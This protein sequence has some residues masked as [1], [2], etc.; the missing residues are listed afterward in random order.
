LTSAPAGSLSFE[1]DELWKAVAIGIAVDD[2]LHGAELLQVDVVGPPTSVA[3]GSE[4]GNFVVP[5]DAGACGIFQVVSPADAP[6][7]YTEENP[8]HTPTFVISRDRDIAEA[9]V[10]WRI[11][12]QISTDSDS[13]HGGS[14]SGLQTAA[15]ISD[16][17]D[18]ARGDNATTVGGE[19]F[20]PVGVTQ[21]T[22]ELNLTDDIVYEPTEHFEFVIDVDQGRCAVAA[23]I[24]PPKVCKVCAGKPEAQSSITYRYTSQ[25]ANTNL[26]GSQA[27]G[28]LTGLFPNKTNLTYTSQPSNAQQT[29]AVVDGSVFTVE[30]AFSY[31]S[32]FTLGSGESFTISTSCSVPLWTGDRFGPLTVLSGGSCDLGDTRYPPVGRVPFTVNVSDVPTTTT[33]TSQSTTTSLVTS[34]TLPGGSMEW[35]PGEYKDIQVAQTTYD[36]PWTVGWRIDLCTDATLTTCG[37]SSS[38]V[39][40][41]PPDGMLVYDPASSSDYSGIISLGLNESGSKSFF[42]QHLR[43]TIFPI[44]QSVGSPHVVVSNASLYLLLPAH[45]QP[46]GYFQFTAATVNVDEGSEHEITISR[47]RGLAGRVRVDLSSID[48]NDGRI[49]LA[50]TS[51]VFE[52]SD[53]A[54]SVNISVPRSDVY[55]LGNSYTLSLHQATLVSTDAS[56]DSVNSVANASLVDITG[57]SDTIRI[58]L[59]DDKDSRGRFNIATDGP[60][61]VANGYSKT[62]QINRTGG[63]LGEVILSLVSTH[64][65]VAFS[66]PR[67]E[68]LLDSKDVC[69][70]RLLDASLNSAEF[71]GVAG[72]AAFSNGKKFEFFE[73]DTRSEYDLQKGEP[74]CTQSP[75]TIPTTAYAIDTDAAATANS[76]TMTSWF[77]WNRIN[78]VVAAGRNMPPAVL[79]LAGDTLQLH[80]A[81]PTRLGA[82]TFVDVATFSVPLFENVQNQVFMVLVTSNSVVVY[83][84]STKRASLLNFVLMQEVTLPAAT[85]ASAVS[86]SHL[87]LYGRHYLAFAAERDPALVWFNDATGDFVVV[88]GGLRGLAAAESFTP[89]WLPSQAACYGSSTN[90]AL[91]EAP[92]QFALGVSASNG[93]MVYHW[94]HNAQN[95]RDSFFE[96]AQVIGGQSRAF[97]VF[98][99]PDENVT[100]L[101]VEPP[102]GGQEGAFHSVRL[103]HLDRGA[104][105]TDVAAYREID[106][107]ALSSTAAG[108]SSVVQRSP[109]GPVEAFVPTA[110]GLR[111]QR[112]GLAVDPET[113]LSVVPAELMFSQDERSK[114]VTVTSAFDFGDVDEKVFEFK[115]ANPRCSNVTDCGAAV[116]MGEKTTQQVVV[117]AAAPALELGR[118]GFSDKDLGSDRVLLCEEG[119]C[120][121]GAAVKVVIPVLRWGKS[122]VKLEGAN[123]LR[124]RFTGPGAFGAASVFSLA[125]IA[126]AEGE[127]GVEAS[128]GDCEEVVGLI[129]L[130][131]LPDAMPEY[132]MEVGIELLA[133]HTAGVEVIAARGT[134]WLLVEQSD[135]PIGGVKLVDADS[136]ATTPRVVTESSSFQFNVTS[137]ALAENRS[138]S[139]H[140][141][142]IYATNGNGNGDDASLAEYKFDPANGT[143]SIA[144]GD[145]VSTVVTVRSRAEYE[146]KQTFLLQLHP[147]SDG[148]PVVSGQDTLQIAVAADR[149]A[150]GVLVP[151]VQ[152]GGNVVVCEAS[153]CPG[154]ARRRSLTGITI[155][156]TMGTSGNTELHFDLLKK[157][158]AGSFEPVG[159]EHVIA[160][161]DSQPS[162]ALDCGDNA[163]A[164]TYCVYILNS[165]E[166]TVTSELR[167]NFTGYFMADDGT[168]IP[169]ALPS[170]SYVDIAVPERAASSDGIR[171]TRAADQSFDTDANAYILPEAGVATTYGVTLDRL[172][173]FFGDESA[174]WELVS[175]LSGGTGDFAGVQGPIQFV[176]GA[177]SSTFQLTVLSDTTPELDDTF[178][179]L[180]TKGDG[181]D[182]A[183]DSAKVVIPAN[184]NPFGVFT[185]A[186]ATY[187]YKDPEH[188]VHLFVERSDG[189]FG[190]VDVHFQVAGALAG[191]QRA[192][193]PLPVLTIGAGESSSNTTLS[194]NGPATVGEAIEVRIIDATLAEGSKGL[195][196]IADAEPAFVDSVVAASPKVALDSA[197]YGRVVCDDSTVVVTEPNSG[198]VDVVFKL[199]REGVNN[200]AS[201]YAYTFAGATATEGVDFAVAPGFEQRTIKFGKNQ[202]NVDFRLQVKADDDPETEELIT[203]A[204]TSITGGVVDPSAQELHVTIEP[205][206]FVGGL[207]GFELLSTEITSVRFAPE[208]RAGI[209]VFGVNILRDFGTAGAAKVTLHGM[210]GDDTTVSEIDFSVVGQQSTTYATGPTLFTTEIDFVDGETV[211]AVRIAVTGDSTPEIEKR[212][213]LAVSVEGILVGERCSVR[214]VTDRTCS[215]SVVNARS[216]QLDMVTPP[217]DNPVGSF[218]VTPGSSKIQPTPLGRSAVA[219]IS[220]AG[221][222]MFDVDLAV[223]LSR[224]ANGCAGAEKSCSEL[225]STVAS[226]DAAMTSVELSSKGWESGCFVQLSLLRE[227]LSQSTVEFAVP[228][229]ARVAIDTQVEIAIDVVGNSPPTTQMGGS[230]VWT[231]STTDPVFVQETATIAATEAVADGQVDFVD[232]PSNLIRNIVEP[233]SGT[234]ALELDFQL[235]RTGGTYTP[236]GTTLVVVCEVLRPGGPNG[237]TPATAI[238]SMG[239]GQT[240]ASLTLRLQPDNLAEESVT[241]IVRIAPAATYAASDGRSIDAAVVIGNTNQARVNIA[242]SDDPYGTIEFAV[243]SRKK[244][245]TVGADTLLFLTRTTG[246]QGPAGSATVIVVVFKDG[247][248]VKSTDDYP[249]PATIDFEPAPARQVKSFRLYTPATAATYTVQL[250]CDTGSGDKVCGGERQASIGPESVALLTVEAQLAAQT[251]A[252]TNDVCEPPFSMALQP[253][254]NEVSSVCDGMDNKAHAPTM[255][256][257]SVRDCVAQVVYF[258]QAVVSSELSLCALS[259]DYV[260]LV[261][262]GASDWAKE[263]GRHPAGQD[264]MASLL[265]HFSTQPEASRICSRYPSPTGAAAGGCNLGVEELSR[266]FAF[267]LLSDCPPTG[268]GDSSCFCTDSASDDSGTGGETYKVSASRLSARNINGTLPANGQLGFTVSARLAIDPFTGP[269]SCEQ[270]A[271]V[272][273]TGFSESFPA[274]SDYKLAGGTV[275]LVAARPSGN[276]NQDFTKDLS[277]AAVTFTVNVGSEDN[278][279][280]CVAWIRTSL[281]EAWSS[282]SCITTPN[283]KDGIVECTCDD[284]WPIARSYGVLVVSANKFS[285]VVIAACAL[286]AMAA[287]IL[288]GTSAL[289]D[290]FSSTRQ[291]AVMIHVGNAVAWLNVVVILNALFSENVNADQR[292]VLGVV[293]HVFGLSVAFGLARTAFVLKALF[294]VHPISDEGSSKTVGLFRWTSPIV[295]WA[296]P[297]LICVIVVVFGLNNSDNDTTALYKDVHGNDRFTFLRSN[298][299]FWLGFAAEVILAVLVSA[300]VGVAAIGA[301]PDEDPPTDIEGKPKVAPLLW[302]SDRIEVGDFKLSMMMV[303]CGFAHLIAGMIAAG[304][305]DDVLEYVF[306][307]ISI[308]FAVAIMVFCFSKVGTNYTV[309][310]V[311]VVEPPTAAADTASVRTTGSGNKIV[312]NS[313]MAPEDG[314]SV[315]G[316]V[317]GLRSYDSGSH[318]VKTLGSFGTSPQSQGAPGYE[319]PSYTSAS[320]DTTEFDDLIFSLNLGPGNAPTPTSA[321]P[322]PHMEA[323]QMMYGAGSTYGAGSGYGSP[324]GGQLSPPGIPMRTLNPAAGALSSAGTNRMSI[325]DTHL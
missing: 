34:L 189:L 185:L 126:S 250:V 110:K 118:V 297:I 247:V 220:R 236:P 10:Q 321:I 149:G 223:C 29:F 30:G 102:C 35:A 162:A 182:N 153:T 148:V 317:P 133:A 277:E 46:H 200:K 121:A 309:T 105:H 60:I 287:I 268:A 275:V 21:R 103:F 241:E 151:R 313:F 55:L 106:S 187:E 283:S 296:M 180:C 208:P 183:T 177:V 76:A 59:A 291:A 271:M 161:A 240:S 129:S 201:E 25:G 263:N 67:S 100:V 256:A 69:V 108:C 73:I 289:L 179:L 9:T 72:K 112:V 192:S 227:G 196:G 122:G 27:F 305:M 74:L 292:F 77:V 210:R 239:G 314:S 18:M 198:R 168:P 254:W 303:G 262:R 145:T 191:S 28:Q 285:V 107:S 315:Q 8:D 136:A 286:V 197:T 22:L 120:S 84:L 123:R 167:L 17:F 214:D 42:D 248:R 265:R 157:T 63:A 89:L 13:D 68:L 12:P 246:Q 251:A 278:E 139:V 96:L 231:M 302:P 172:G 64:D 111:I 127:Y 94:N 294:R 211:K 216:G 279:L 147:S 31:R 83:K 116:A 173:G 109:N 54:K 71:A 58:V 125:S 20:F 300:F 130:E 66:A 232:T 164:Q 65:S 307:G 206:D 49:V 237:L 104:F 98:L 81:D 316:S 23:S 156:R 62:M 308:V 195:A 93:S 188:R 259:I 119:E 274:P 284:V 61:T 184:G 203:I 117:P 159:A 140:S 16:D 38:G 215:D 165:E 238:V 235:T 143:I 225:G 135:N 137:L 171:L 114:T 169:A 15:N 253:L 158:E 86:V 199:R 324:D 155:D 97:K 261:L 48:P 124:W 166:L 80:Q 115:L 258:M 213:R 144:P 56:V 152:D 299:L 202:V 53:T 99:L 222:A 282:D 257:K 134:L 270:I 45:N 141:W 224:S 320:V 70:P 5:E 273:T 204:L 318:A 6:A 219:I 78:Y 234:P 87:E 131:V 150:Y 226:A 228:N 36:V 325:A 170:P 138:S 217:N 269:R 37:N 39:R 260:A 88:E 209:K 304:V 41:D 255:P 101:G 95:P 160:F 186:R 90:D 174:T 4:S 43:L 295:I 32:K 142:G 193:E 249:N 2:V 244:I 163:D 113:Q 218:S 276:S 229:T 190:N 311:K 310:E 230:K 205:N 154:S 293:T 24:I 146:P 264:V 176:D 92:A 323:P 288:I 243:E 26:Q 33:T 207:F 75:P 306:A 50:N 212:L 312:M 178:T 91:G 47:T 51:V 221:G 267:S 82:S 3:N 85:Q 175:A 79:K 322:D 233:E 281:S 301:E 44:N 272:E 1:P 290:G 245:P 11:V 132:A 266:E 319:M 128:G 280:K 40:L 298:G 194:F 19:I 7:V 181:P 252:G 242:A 14:G 57:P 52:Q